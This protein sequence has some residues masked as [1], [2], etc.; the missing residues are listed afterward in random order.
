M[1]MAVQRVPDRRDE[2]LY[3]RASAVEKNLLS[4]A[5]KASQVPVSQFMRQAALRS[6]EDVLADQTRFVLPPDK[7]SE[8]T[9]LLERPARVPDA[10]RAAASRPSP[11]VER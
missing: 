5:A 9:A 4:Q 1:S 2:R 7:W 8:F 11:F 10:L 6:A 3:V